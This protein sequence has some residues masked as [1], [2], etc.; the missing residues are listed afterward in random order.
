MLYWTVDGSVGSPD[1]RAVPDPHAS[2]VAISGLSAD[3]LGDSPRFSR[4]LQVSLGF[5]SDIL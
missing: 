2:R 1:A 5:S 3:H 4:I